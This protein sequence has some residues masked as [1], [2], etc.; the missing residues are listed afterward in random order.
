[1]A[2]TKR[3][4]RIFMLPFVGGLVLL[5]CFWC[6]RPMLLGHELVFPA[7]VPS[8]ARKV[9]EDRY[10]DPTFNLREALGLMR[11][12]LQK[13]RHFEFTRRIEFTHWKMPDGSHHSVHVPYGISYEFLEMDGHWTFVRESRLMSI[14]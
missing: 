4:A 11:H 2:M 7:S 1:M 12:P 10:P 3:T 6:L 13:R 8:D 5:Y 9:I 14:H